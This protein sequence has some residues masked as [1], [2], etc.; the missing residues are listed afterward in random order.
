MNEIMLPE[1]DDIQVSEEKEIK[2]KQPFA[3]KMA[4][5]GTGQ[6][7]CKLAQTF[8][9]LGFARV[10]GVNTT[11]KDVVGDLPL[12]LM[13]GFD[14]AGKNP[15]KGKEA[16]EEYKSDILEFCHEK[17]GSDTEYLFI[18]VG[19]GGGTGTG[20]TTTLIQVAKDYFTA[21]RKPVRVGVIAT[22]PR[23]TEGS[24]VF[25]NAVNLLDEL[26]DK[27]VAREIAPLILI[28]NKKIA[29]MFSKVVSMKDFWTVANKNACSMFSI[30]NLLANQRS[31]Y[32]TFDK[33]DFESVL[34]SGIITFGTTRVPDYDSVTGISKAIR[35]N[36][37]NGLFATG[38][39][40]SSAT[41]VAAMLAANPNVLGTMPADAMEHS[42]KTLQ[43]VL[44]PRLTIHRGVYEVTNK[45]LFLYTMIGGLAKPEERL[46]ELKV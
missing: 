23:D 17:F 19:A 16:A 40:F 33:K 28:D 38:F 45:A 7:G 8:G 24:Q 46:N 4:F 11:D 42:V 39:D 32:E 3:I 41:C 15:A 2:D 37:E 29:S 36:L 10:A 12:Y 5:L 21:L 18:C 34:D 26:C 13:E 22:I 20:S 43:S 35:K 6:G 44:H 27:A 14:G 31:E 25:G 30:F 1:M 9:S